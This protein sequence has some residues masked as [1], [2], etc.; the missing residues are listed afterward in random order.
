MDKAFLPLQALSFSF[1]LLAGACF[2]ASHQP[3]LRHSVQQ[4]FG[5]AV[6]PQPGVVRS[7]GTQHPKAVKVLALPLDTPKTTISLRTHP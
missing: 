4:Q 3:S 5:H 7:A 2:V 6:S 1:F